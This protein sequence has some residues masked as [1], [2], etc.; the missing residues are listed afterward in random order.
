[1][2]V[3]LG[4]QTC[5]NGNSINIIRSPTPSAA[6]VVCQPLTCYVTDIYPVTSCKSRK[7]HHK[8]DNVRGKP[9]LSGQQFIL[10]LVNTL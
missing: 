3:W 6:K 5:N 7:V 4:R 8:L 9:N 1:M 2:S 10:L